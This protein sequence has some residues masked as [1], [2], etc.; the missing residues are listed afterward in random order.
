MQ[1]II[2]DLQTRL[3]FQEDS[4]EAVN[5]AMVRQRSEIDLLKK[6]IIRLKE[7][8]EDIRETRRSG[9][10]EVELPPHY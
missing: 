8:I 7:M 9:E 4:L 5:L 6:E 1:E 10:S 2:I 3:A